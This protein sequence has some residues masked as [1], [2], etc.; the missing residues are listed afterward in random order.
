MD[1]VAIHGPSVFVHGRK[2]V[3]VMRVTGLPHTTYWPESN[4]DG[5]MIRALRNTKVEL[6]VI[7]T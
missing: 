4:V 6:I 7:A 5:A 1:L 2:V 3:I